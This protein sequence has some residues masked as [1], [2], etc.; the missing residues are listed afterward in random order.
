MAEEKRKEAERKSAMKPHEKL[1]TKTQPNIFI[2]RN[3]WKIS[4]W[5]NQSRFAVD[6][7]ERGNCMPQMNM[8]IISS[9]DPFLFFPPLKISFSLVSFFF[10]W[11]RKKEVF[12]NFFAALKFVWLF[13]LPPPFPLSV[14][15]SRFWVEKLCLHFWLLLARTKNFCLCFL[16]Y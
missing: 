6:R 4:F 14:L 11:R 8:G 1:Y 5:V 7:W 9:A 13:F 16:S 3:E 10:S 15:Q 2:P 12:E